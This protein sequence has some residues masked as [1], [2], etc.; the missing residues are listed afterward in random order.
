[1]GIE[2]ICCAPLL[3]M[4]Q[5]ARSVCCVGE[6]DGALFRRL[7]NWEHEGSVKC[8]SGQS[9]GRVPGRS[10]E[11]LGSGIISFIDMVC[12]GYSLSI[13]TRREDHNYPNPHEPYRRSR[14][15][16]G[17]MSLILTTN[18]IRFRYPSNPTSSAVP[19]V[20]IQTHRERH[21]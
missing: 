13:H 20:Q 1:M 11:L 8:Q 17:F 16:N 18:E 7:F 6:D 9:G 21:C 4:L 2:T 15:K 5:R 10:N 14:P 12:G 19:P 3:R